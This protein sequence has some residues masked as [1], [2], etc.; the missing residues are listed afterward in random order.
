MDN[1]VLLTLQN[2]FLLLKS[3]TLENTLTKHIHSTGK[4]A[5]N[6]S[7]KM[8]KWKISNFENK[9]ISFNINFR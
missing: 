1:F 8:N 3:V 4:E 9:I 6:F 5:G 2:W 7:I